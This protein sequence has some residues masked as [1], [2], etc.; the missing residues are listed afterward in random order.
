V[1]APISAADFLPATESHRPNTAKGNK[2]HMGKTHE[3]IPP[4]FQKKVRRD[5][6]FV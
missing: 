4:D 2:N 6:N 1:T 3:E 5:L